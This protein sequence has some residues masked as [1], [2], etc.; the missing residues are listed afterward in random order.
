MTKIKQAL[1]VAAIICS[2]FLNAQELNHAEVRLSYNEFKQLLAQSQ[3]K[4]TEKIPQPELLSARIGLSMTKDQPVLNTTFKTVSFGSKVATAPLIGGNV[5]I[6]SQQP[7]SAVVVMKNEMLSLTTQKTGTH[8][9]DLTILPQVKGQ[10]CSFSIPPCP[11]AIFSVDSLPDDQ[12]IILEFNGHEHALIQGQSIPITHTSGPLTLRFLSS[13][14]TRKALLPPEPSTW[15]WQHQALVD[16]IDGELHYQ[17]ISTASATDGSGVSA[18]VPMPPDA[19]YIE[20]TSDDLTSYEK[21]RGENRALNLKLNW[22]TRGILDRKVFIRYRMP[23]RPL[24]PTWTLQAPGDN[25]TRTRFILPQNP[26]LVYTADELTPP[27]RSQG[28]PSA[29]TILL[30]GRNCHYLEAKS[31]AK[32]AVETIPVAAIAKGTVISAGW[33]TRIEPDGAMLV[34]GNLLISHQDSLNFKFDTPAGMKLLSCELNGSAIAPADL[35]DGQLMINLP[36]NR[37]DSQLSC[38]FTG[39]NE[40][41]DLVEGTMKLKLPQTPTFIHSLEWQ[42]ELPVGYQSETHGNLKRFNPTKNNRPSTIALRKN[43]CRDERPEVQVF[44]QRTD[45]KL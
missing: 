26:L 1:G 31:S 25:D 19:R 11:S 7:D 35:G 8:T 32:V 41:L 16:P 30:D 9:V 3:P 44:Y 13:K 2:P 5:S 10:S 14:E 27:S 45:L 4:T 21:I 20:V 43:L 28:L 12:S 22:K 6:S 23:L 40:A 34:S 42:V 39:N 24:D 36:S 18:T 17:I 37:K 38:S 15:T 33:K 29:L